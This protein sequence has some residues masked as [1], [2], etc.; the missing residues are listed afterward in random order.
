M[1]GH[2]LLKQY[3]IILGCGKD[4]VPAINEAKLLGLKVVAF[5]QNPKSVG[6]SYCDIFSSI[7]SRDVKGISRYVKD[8]EILRDNIAG[9]F[10]MGTDLTDVA[11]M[12]CK[13]VNCP[14][15]SIETAKKATDKYLMK[16][17]FRN[18]GLP[19]PKFHLIESW[20]KLKK[21]LKKND[22]TK[23]VLK[24]IDR[25]GARGVARVSSKDISLAK[26]SYMNA[27]YLS[28]KRYLLLEE[29]LE[30]PQLST[31]SIVKDGKCITPGFA[32]RNY[33]LLDKF[34]PNFIENGGVQ[35]SIHYSNYHEEIDALI[36][37]IATAIGL[38]RGVIKGDLVIDPLRGPM[39]IEVAARLSG[40]DFSESLIPLTTGYNLIGSALK[41]MLFDTQELDFSTMEKINF[42]RYA[43]NRYF[44]AKPGVIKSITGL[45]NVGDTEGLIKMEMNVQV[46]DIVENITDH[47]K[48]L[49][50]FL[51]VADTVEEL[52]V[53]INKIYQQV[54][55]EID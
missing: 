37:E 51:V 28:R 35:P 25:S 53:R 49:G 40:G 42:T 39:I 27:K 26:K 21:F 38:D 13:E 6:A 47:S 48:R 43:A 20:R 17:A 3:L 55:I 32:D 54:K 8:N 36:P 23:F 22:G 33:E 19:I 29:Y 52:N 30:G 9:V 2:I 44:F 50:V 7:S 1:G 15:L 24:P 4:Q 14:G 41:L 34:H 12:I 46:G 18:K 16:K 31:E 10:V 11:A 45:E 5:D